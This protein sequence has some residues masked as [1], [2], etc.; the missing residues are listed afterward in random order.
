MTYA[1]FRRTLAGGIE[2]W[3]LEVDEAA[4][5]R[6]E[7]HYAALVEANRRFNL[8]AVTGEAEA[9]ALHFL[10]ALAFLRYKEPAPGESLIDVGSGAGFPG[11]V[12]KAARPALNVVLLESSRKK[13]EFLRQ[14][15]AA[16]ELHGAEAVWGR[17]ED[18]ARR[19]GRREN[20]DWAVARG[21]AAMRVLCE[22]CLP[23]VRTGGFFVAYKGPGV[24]PE[25]QEARRAF[26]ILG[27]EVTAVE[28]FPLLPA[29]EERRLVFVKK[30]RRTPAE[31]PRRAGLPVRRPL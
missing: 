12:L 17:A 7:R 27:G 28:R 21:V 13:A 30:V 9:A 3:G 24:E 6:F 18:D 19:P 16:L 25:L 20:F 4:L 31:Y 1:L 22:Y 10:D 8:T 5:E 2:A 11:L 23:F 15:I 26:S 14:V 29:G